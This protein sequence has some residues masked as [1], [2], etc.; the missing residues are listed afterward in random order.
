MDLGDNYTTGLDAGDSSL[1]DNLPTKTSALRNGTI[2]SICLCDGKSIKSFFGYIS[3]H[4]TLTLV[5]TP[6]GLEI[7]ETSFVELTNNID[8]IERISFKVDQQLE[9]CF[10]P[11][12]IDGEGDKSFI[13]LTIPGD[14]LLSCV[15][16]SKVGTSLRLEYNQKRRTDIA[17]SV[18]NNGV[19]VTKYISVVLSKSNT[20]QINSILAE[21]K[22][23]PMCSVVSDSFSLNMANNSKKVRSVGYGTIVEIFNGGMRMQSKAPKVDPVS[24]GE[25]NGTPFTFHLDPKT[26]IRF[27][28]L[29]KISPKTPIFIDADE[30]I[31]KIRM[32]ICSY[33]KITIFQFNNMYQPKSGVSQGVVSNG[34]SIEDIAKYNQY[35]AELNA[36]YDSCIRAG[37]ITPQAAEID[38]TQKLQQVWMFLANQVQSRMMNSNTGYQQIYQQRQNVQQP[39]HQTPNN[40]YQQSSQS[41]NPVSA[42]NHLAQIRAN[43]PVSGQYSQ[44][45]TPQQVKPTPN[46]L[47]AN[48]QQMSIMEFN[49]NSIQ[50]QSLP[51]TGK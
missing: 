35:N 41:Q 43:E 38:K 3:S 39:L 50:I 51:A 31:M 29:G 21:D 28:K 30:N 9:Y 10:C 13:A 17:A 47:Q 49:P 8:Y 40:M 19:P 36:Y 25:T 46:H 2:A 42:V 44:Q 26:T 18:I 23:E 5:F 24:F 1:L 22:V 37:Q 27:G 6:D 32:A 12:N 45:N 20:L 16:N 4:K 14:A 15:S 48:I 34:F 11:Q 7:L 33:A